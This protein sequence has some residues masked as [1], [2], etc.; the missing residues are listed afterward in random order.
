MLVGHRN[1]LGSAT[2]CHSVMICRP[3]VASQSYLPLVTG[4]FSGCLLEGISSGWLPDVC[5]GQ[6]PQ[7]LCLSGGLLRCW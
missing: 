1:G 4:R 5:D 3:D 7:M 2:P 6:G